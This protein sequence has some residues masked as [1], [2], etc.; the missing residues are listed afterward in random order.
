[1]FSFP[2]TLLLNFSKRANNGASRVSGTLKKKLVQRDALILSTS[3]GPDTPARGVLHGSPEHREDPAAERSFTQ[4]LQRGGFQIFSEAQTAAHLGT[5][6]VAE[7][8]AC[9]RFFFYYPFFQKVE[10]PLHM[11]SRAGHYEVAEFLLQNGAPVDAKAK[12]TASSSSLFEFD[13]QSSSVF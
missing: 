13:V 7:G 9:D 4:R 8:A 1:M 3:V 10:T 12:V 6:D 2:T 5:Q 11:A